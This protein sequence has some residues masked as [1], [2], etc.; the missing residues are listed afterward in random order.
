VKVPVSVI[1]S[2]KNEEKN[3]TSCL[4]RLK[5]FDE[6]IVVD[7]GSTDSTPEIVKN[8]GHSLINFR[9]NG[10]FPKKRNW[11]LR[12]LSFKNDW[13]LFLDADEQ[14]TPDF[15]KEISI[16]VR[17]SDYSGFW[18][19]Y[20]DHF[21]GKRLRFGLQMRKLSLFK[22][23]AGEYERIDE[24]SWSHLD[25]EVHEHPIV[26]G[27]IGTLKSHIIH[28]DYKGLE[29]YI[30]RHNAYSTWEAKRYLQL[31]RDKNGPL[32]FRQRIKYGLIET[33][34]LPYIYFLGAYFLKLGFL[35]GKEG[36][37]IAQYKK[38][39]FFQI[40]TKIKELSR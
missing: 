32:T 3:L 19:N 14:V 6:V 36:F 15:V 10:K 40:Q 2:V 11:A 25:M 5:D 22:K 34:L 8:Y 18:V 16:L 1:V 27:K 23:S 33:G 35:D 20:Q 37:Y 39:Y 26:K 38:Q 17:K 29:R 13:I 28:N 30:E 9:W 4:S 21:M 31:K 7:S 12:N 24:D